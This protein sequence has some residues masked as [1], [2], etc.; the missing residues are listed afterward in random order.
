MSHE[1]RSPNLQLR[2][3]HAARQR[4]PREGLAISNAAILAGA[5]AKTAPEFIKETEYLKRTIHKLV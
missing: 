3:A 4:R 1:N 2:E 5:A